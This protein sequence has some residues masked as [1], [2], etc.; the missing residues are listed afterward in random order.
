MVVGSPVIKTPL[1]NQ[2][3]LNQFPTLDGSA[4]SSDQ[5]RLLLA[6]LGVAKGLRAAAARAGNC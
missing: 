6:C 3:F 2:G 4:G 1:E 5:V